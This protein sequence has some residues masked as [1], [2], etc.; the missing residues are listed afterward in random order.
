MSKKLDEARERRLRHDLANEV[1]AK[2]LKD[3]RRHQAM[4][5][6]SQHYSGHDHYPHLH[7]DEED[8]DAEV[9]SR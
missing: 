8:D 7:H 3:A 2:A 6:A 1:Y 4:L 5:H 9:Q